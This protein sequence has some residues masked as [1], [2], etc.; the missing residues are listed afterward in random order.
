MEALKKEFFQSLQSFRIPIQKIYP[1]SF[2]ESK[3]LIYG[4]IRGEEGKKWVVLG[5][6][7]AVRRDPFIGRSYHQ[8]LT[9]KVC[10]L[11]WENTQI[12][13]ECFPF[14]RPKSLKEFPT[15]FGAGDRLGLATPGHLRAIRK[16]LIRPVLAQQSVRENHQTGRDFKRV[17]QDAA[18]AVIQERYESGY[19]A[20]GDHLKSLQEVKEALDAGV[21]MITLDLS[22]KLSPESVWISKEEVEKK[23]ER[24][25]E[26]EDRKVLLHLFLDK[27]F[28]FEGP[29]CFSIQYTEEEVK[30]NALLFHKGIDLSEEIYEFLMKEK[31]RKPLIDFEISIDET[32]FPTSLSNHL[33]LILN[34]HHRGVRI[35]SLALRF[36]GEFQKGIDYR[37][38]IHEFR[39]HFSQ[40]LLIAKSNGDYKLSI[41]SGS[42]KFS[43]FPHLGE[44][45]QGHLHLKTAG[46]SWLEALRL[47]SFLDPHLF[48]EIVQIA[49][50]KFEEASKLYQV[51]TDLKKIPIIEDISDRDLSQ[52][53]D[54]EDCRQLLHITYGFLLKG[55]LKDRIFKTLTEHEE[56][57]WSLLQSH[58]EKHLNALGLKKGG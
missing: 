4:L 45:S 37:G 27:E 23:F 32:P 28:S 14:T 54:Q 16:F 31:G 20:D 41:H 55:V 24:E 11:D 38:E 52:L 42:D 22:E 33:F 47:I 17:I 49:L 15:T 48:R 18:W 58:I 44:L 8:L 9:L 43:I 34:L 56:E 25:I 19:G 13:M 35:D 2:S 53:L 51:S 57:Y 12:L 7:E 50:T 10:D 46:T 3:G 36:V 30:R 39:K 26:E 6:R 21:S 5:E 1:Q 29:D 40:H